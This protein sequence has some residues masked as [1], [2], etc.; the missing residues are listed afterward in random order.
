MKN[1]FLINKSSYMIIGFILLA[2]LSS[3]CTSED[4]Q[5]DQDD[6]D[7]YKISLKVD[8]V[9][10][11]F[12]NPDFP[13][14]GSFAD[15]GVQYSGSFSGT[16][17]ASSVGIQVYDTKPIV[18]NVNYDGLVVTATAAGNTLFGSIVSF[19]DSQKS[20]TTQNGTNQTVHVKFTELTANHARGEFSGKLKLQGGTQEV[21]VIEGK[22]YVEVR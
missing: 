9:L 3:S 12:K 17:Q 1:Q 2:L 5:D 20:Y 21:T 19:A 7:G 15:N 18:V 6:S 22:F 14:F 13:P 10:W 11:E 8:G 4:G 16:G